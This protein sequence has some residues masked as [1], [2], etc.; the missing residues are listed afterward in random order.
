MRH[1]RNS[2]C[3]HDHLGGGR[4]P[5]ANSGRR[6]SDGLSPTT[7]RRSRV[8]RSKPVPA[9]LVDETLAGYDRII[10]LDLSEVADGAQHTVPFGG[11][12]TGPDPATEA[13]VDGSGRPRPNATGSRSAANK[14]A[15]TA[16]TASCS[17]PPW[18]RSTPAYSSATSRRCT[19]TSAT[20]TARASPT[21]GSG[22][23]EQHWTTVR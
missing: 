20:T 13:N 2:E 11:G 12:G 16:T 23:S 19:S 21:T 3:C 17:Q 7:P 6:P 18:T 9:R 22:R 14:P 1:R 15:R 4:T 5:V 8:L 10:G